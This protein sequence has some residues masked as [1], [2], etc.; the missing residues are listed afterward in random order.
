MASQYVC[1]HLTAHHDIAAGMHYLQ[2]FSRD[3]IVSGL[4]CHGALQ[5]DDVVFPRSCHSSAP[6]DVM[7]CNVV[8]VFFN[9]VEDDIFC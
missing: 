6:T 5:L 7:L 4:K 8:A 3:F 2:M 1:G 9:V